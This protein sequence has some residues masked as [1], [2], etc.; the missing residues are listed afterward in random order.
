MNFVIEELLSHHEV[1]DEDEKEEL[2]SVI[3][4]TLILSI[5]VES[6]NCER[7]LSDSTRKYRCSSSNLSHFKFCSQGLLAHTLCKNLNHHNFERGRPKGRLKG[8]TTKNV[9]FRYQ[10]MLYLCEIKLSGQGGHNFELLF[11]REGRRG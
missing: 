2:D 5:D 10:Y 1:C 6:L 9:F 8:A 11:L 4:F 3:R 7:S